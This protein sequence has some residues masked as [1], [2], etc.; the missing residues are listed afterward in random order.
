[1]V[2]KAI[3][4]CRP[5]LIFYSSYHESGKKSGTAAPAPYV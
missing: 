1:M 2:E 3:T 5:P 4:V